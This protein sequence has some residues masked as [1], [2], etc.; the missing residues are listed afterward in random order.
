MELLAKASFQEQRHQ[1]K[2]QK[3]LTAAA[4]NHG[5]LMLAYPLLPQTMFYAI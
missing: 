2:P 3:E 5:S 1:G 4:A